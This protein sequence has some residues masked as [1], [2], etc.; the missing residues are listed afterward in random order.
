LNRTHFYASSRVPLSFDR[1]H[2]RFAIYI[3]PLLLFLYQIQG[4]LQ[5]IRCQSSP[6]W[7]EMQYGTS[8]RRLDTDFA[9]EGGYLWQTASTLLF[10][11]T[12]EDS[13]RA[14]NMLPVDADST[15]LS[16]SLAL[17]WPLFLSIG[18]SQFVETLSCA[19]QGRHPVQEAGMTIFEHS[20]AFAEAE[21]VVTKPL[22]LDTARFFKPRSIFTPD[23]T[24][25]L[26]PRSGLNKIANV[27][28]EVLIISLISSI[29]HY[30]SNTLAIAGVRSRY[31]LV[32]T[33]IWGLAYMA[34]FTWSFLKLTNTIADPNHSSVGLL[35]FPTVCIVGFIPHLLILVGIAACGLIYLLA[36]FITVLSPPPGHP[37]SLSLR[38]RFAVAYENLHANIHMS[39][40]TPLTVNWNEDFYTAILKVGFT[41]LTAASEAVFLNEGTKVNVHP[42]TWIEK[43]RLEDIV[44]RRRQFQQ[45]LTNVPQELRGGTLAAGVEVTDVLD[46]SIPHQGATSGYAQERKTRGDHGGA[47][48]ARPAGRNDPAGLAQRRS[49][50]LLTYR[51]FQSISKLIAAIHARLVIS[52]LTTLRVTYRPRWLSRLAGPGSIEKSH[53]TVLRANLNTPQAAPESWLTLDDRS[54]VRL[55]SNFDV[56]TFA[57]ERLRQSTFYASP[58]PEESEERL[59][60]YLYSWWRNGGR[61]GDVDSSNDYAPPQDDDNTSVISFA[62][63]DDSDW[64]DEEDGQRTPTRDTYQRMRESTPSED[65]TMDLARLSHLLDPKTNE[66]REEAKLLARH[67]ESSNV[68][69]R[70]QYK[71]MRER[72][73]AKILT[74]SRYKMGNTVHMTA[75]EE[76]QLLEDFIL[77]RRAAF[78]PTGQSTAGSWDTG[79][80]GMGAEGPQCV[81]CQLS[82]RTVLVWPCGCLSL[83][84]ECRVGL[85]SKN[86][87]ACVCCRTNVVAYSRLYVP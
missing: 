15:R 20:L 79:A 75:E 36:L 80:E 37:Q 52:L 65:H 58:D 35:R 68:L 43:K 38:E 8:G 50:F 74:T 78:P 85:A 9:G 84:D 42:M 6:G 57:K 77:D 87:T 81:V 73:E 34:T 47:D 29:S 51:F 64:S 66:D 14:V 72:D 33:T 69:T 10:W 32:T 30:T 60:D 63:T 46:D 12:T 40:S 59:N 55:D 18:F 16:G 25:F 62:T 24:S 11:E 56:E 70:S 31:R 28:T 7:S 4:V 48:T 27:P 71:K 44:S 41:V 13:C 76:E 86:Y 5:A 54:R 39:A 45:R 2:L 21:A 82:P 19:L 3:A 1:V 61:W 83:C 26:M 49:R 23:G 53:S 17:L 67:L 22:A